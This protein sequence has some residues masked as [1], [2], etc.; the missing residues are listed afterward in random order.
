METTS[1]KKDSPFPRHVPVMGICGRAGCNMTGV[2]ASI[3]PQL[4]ARGLRVAVVVVDQESESASAPAHHPVFSTGSDLILSDGK[5]IHSFCHQG[6]ERDLFTLLHQQVQHYDLLLVVGEGKTA[7]RKIWLLDE[8]EQIPPA[9]ATNI[10]QVLPLEGREKRIVDYLVSWLNRTWLQT[11]LWG[12]VLIGGMSS[13]MGRPKHLIKDAEGRSWLE[14][15]VEILSQCTENIVLSGSGEVSESLSHLLRLPD[16]PECGGPLTGILS[17]MRWQPAYSWLLV[18]CDM[19]HVNDAALQWL[20]EQRRPGTWATIPTRGEGQKM[21]PL[22]AHYDFRCAPLCEALLRTGSFRIGK[23]GKE[24]KVATPTIPKKIQ[25][26][27]WNINTPEELQKV[28]RSE[29]DS[30]GRT[31]LT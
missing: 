31:G 11:P 23:L 2:V 5:H 25:T 22:L 14:R 9:W 1:S 10:E 3:L 27:W 30:A 13:R 21:E 19:P 20:L 17:A 24:T 18:A 4:I 12:C 28:I 8:D 29:G 15:T 16:I 6:E 7:E 26:A